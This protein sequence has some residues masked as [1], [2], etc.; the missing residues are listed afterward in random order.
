MLSTIAFLLD[1]VVKRIPCPTHHIPLLTDANRNMNVLCVCVCV[2]YHIAQ[3]NAA[4]ELGLLIVTSYEENGRECDE[5][6]LGQLKRV[7]EAMTPGVEMSEFLKRA[8]R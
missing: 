1:Q 4:T 7:A 3:L 5:A 8:I 2:S 6:R